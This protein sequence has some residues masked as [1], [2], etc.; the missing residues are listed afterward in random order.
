MATPFGA[1]GVG[2]P[3]TN[4]A[5]AATKPPEG[6]VSE[7]ITGLVG[8]FASLTIIRKTQSVKS[9]GTAFTGFPNPDGS[10]PKNEK[11]LVKSTP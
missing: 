3:G 7:R 5:V 11:V 1:D 10:G 8:S 6:L 2:G 9:R 4:V